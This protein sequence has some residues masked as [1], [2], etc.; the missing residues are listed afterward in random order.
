MDVRE[1]QPAKV[2]SPMLFT[3]FGML[4][5]VSDLHKV[6]ALFPML[7]TELGI[8]TDV[9]EEHQE[10]T[11]SP[12][13]VTPFFITIFFILSRSEIQGYVLISP[14]PDMVNVPSLDRFHVISAW[15][16]LKAIML[17]KISIKNFFIV[18]INE[19]GRRPSE[20]L[21]L[22]TGIAKHLVCRQAY[23]KA[24]ALKRT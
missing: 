14:V 18:G 20:I 11:L 5:E 16:A 6:K 3:E 21:V 12:I 15:I 17:N 22:F 23:E 13:F 7:I 1:E 19:I 9:K 4:M 10:K 24:H 8:L 2:F